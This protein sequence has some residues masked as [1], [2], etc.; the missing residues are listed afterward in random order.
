MQPEGLRVWTK[1]ASEAGQFA[2]ATTREPNELERQLVVGQ[3][4]A[5]I[6]TVGNTSN[7]VVM[8]A[9]VGWSIP[10][11]QQYDVDETFRRPVTLRLHST[12]DGAWV[13]SA[14]GERWTDEE[15]V[16]TLVNTLREWVA[17]NG[18]FRETDDDLY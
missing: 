4:C 10:V 16:A 17:T 15:V 7:P 13:N 18:R 5:T 11:Y 14:N 9:S 6:D 1:L 12:P 2:D 8:N 3:F